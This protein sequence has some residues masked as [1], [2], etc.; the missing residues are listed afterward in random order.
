MENWPKPREIVRKGSFPYI[1][2]IEEDFTYQTPWNLKQ[3]F[4]VIPKPPLSAVVIVPR[5]FCPKMRPC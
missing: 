2:K 5:G 4:V 3:P 1:F